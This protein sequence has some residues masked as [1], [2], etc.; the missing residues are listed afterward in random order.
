MQAVLNFFPLLSF[1]SKLFHV[2]TY[3]TSLGCYSLL[4]PL[5]IFPRSLPEFCPICCPL[6]LVKL[7]NFFLHPTST[8]NTK[9]WQGRLIGGLLQWNRPPSPS[10]YQGKRWGKNFDLMSCLFSIYLLSRSVK[11]GDWLLIEDVHLAPSDVMS[12]LL[13]L[14]ER[15]Q[16]HVPSRGVVIDAS[17]GWL[18]I[19]SLS[20]TL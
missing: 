18:P 11:A 5:A 3:L 12:T 14:I 4:L 16:L 17:P 2:F 1:R 9:N 6:W 13:P 15:R 20:L 10:W 19:K 8:F 7:S